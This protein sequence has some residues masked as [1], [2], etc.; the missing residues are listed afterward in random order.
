MFRPDPARYYCVRCLAG[1]GREG[2]ASLAETRDHLSFSHHLPPSR[3]R[4]DQDWVA[5]DRA[6]DLLAARPEDQ[7]ERVFRF[8]L[9][10]AG[11]VGVD[12]VVAEVSR[13]PELGC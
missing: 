9:Y 11:C 5:G 7:E 1:P 2:F 3:Q 13:R 4:V 10:L 8:A 12:D 6:L